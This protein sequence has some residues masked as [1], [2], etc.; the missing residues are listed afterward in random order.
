M[1]A[2]AGREK[3]RMSSGSTQKLPAATIPFMLAFALIVSALLMVIA[4]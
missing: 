2:P 3:P 1:P 4:R